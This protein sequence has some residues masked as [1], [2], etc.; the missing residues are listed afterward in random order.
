MLFLKFGYLSKLVASPTT[1]P[2]IPRQPIGATFLVAISLLGVIAVIQLS[3]VAWHYSK[4]VKQ[5]MLAA[6]TEAREEAVAPPTASPPNPSAAA[7]TPVP[8]EL[9]RAQK[10]FAEADRHFRVGEFEKALGSLDE[11]EAIMPGDPSV[12]LRKA[13]I[14]EKLGR[15]A[16]A[17]VALEAAL[18]VPGLP[19]N[20]QDQAKKKLLL[21]SERIG[22]R[23]ASNPAS[24]REPA[25]VG[26]IRDDMRDPIGLQP[27]ADLGIVDTRLQDGSAGLKRLR[28]AVKSR[29]GVEIKVPD[30]RIY[31]YFYEVTETG[32]IVITDSRVKT[33][34]LSPPVDWADNEPELLLG[35][36]ILPESGRSGSSTANGTPGRKYHGYIV[37]V[38]YHQDLQDFRSEPAAL[39]KEFPVPL[40]LKE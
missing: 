6:A 9:L 11:V 38:Y 23:E 29:P 33:E 19:P 17:V 13:E 10:F 8:A 21:L 40:Y 35:Q 14:L 36:Y 20:I 1:H 16:E 12:S 22:E 26:E 5:Q 30:V 27:G 37:A 15:P 24:T 18:N 32:E 7:A 28:V 31:I 25:V 39:A 4:L 34:W 2:P 3:A